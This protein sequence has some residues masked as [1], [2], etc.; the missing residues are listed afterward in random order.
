[1]MELYH[2]YNYIN[3]M[4]GINGKLKI[5]LNLNKRYITLAPVSNLLGIAFELKDPNNL[6]GK[7][8]ISVALVE[9]PHNYFYLHFLKTQSM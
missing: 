2:G 6:L 4:N 3:F 9:R 7:T 1:M 5:K 8:G